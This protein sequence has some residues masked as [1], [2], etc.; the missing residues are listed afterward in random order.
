MH[1][2]EES[3]STSNLIILGFWLPKPCLPNYLEYCLTNLLHSDL[4]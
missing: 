4:P 2:V 1:E 3:G